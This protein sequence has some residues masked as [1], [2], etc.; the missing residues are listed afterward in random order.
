MT[1]EAI[2]KIL[3]DT[4]VTAAESNYWGSW[5]EY[6]HREGEETVT[7]WEDSETDKGTVHVLTPEDL[8]KTFSGI[9]SGKIEAPDYVREQVRLA[10]VDPEMVDIDAD[11]ADILVQLTLFRDKNGQ[12]TVVFG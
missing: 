12:P 5:S 7:I 2:N 3:S 6:C 9:Y 11:A 4:F 10:Y 8:R 1:L